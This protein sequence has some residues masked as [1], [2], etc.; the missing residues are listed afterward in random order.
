MTVVVNRSTRCGTVDPSNY[1]MTARTETLQV[2]AK[3]CRD[4]QPSRFPAQSTHASDSVALS[5]QDDLRR[6]LDALHWDKV[7]PFMA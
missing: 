1:S 7:W 3:S 2:R 6:L 5:E 4:S